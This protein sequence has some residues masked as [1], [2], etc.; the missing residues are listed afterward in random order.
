MATKINNGNGNGK[1]NNRPT[2]LRELLIL[3][4]ESLYDIE[5]ELIKALPKMAKGA[6]HPELNAAFNEHL[7]QTKEHAKRLEHGLKLLGAKVSKLKT[8]GIR[9]IIKDGEWIIHTIKDEDARDA[10]L[11]AAAQY[12]EHYEIAG[13]DAAKKWAD[14]LGLNEVKDLLSETLKEEEETS[15]K[16]EGLAKSEINSHVAISSI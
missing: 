6:T 2:D 16:L 8:E 14:I 13:Y 5:Q 4:L 3:K 11:V 10:S 15:K 7:K 12:A 1:L 9:G